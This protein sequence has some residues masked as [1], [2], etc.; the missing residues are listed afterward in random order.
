MILTLE[1]S[2]WKDDDVAGVRVRIN[3]A[4]ATVAD[5]RADI[6][7]AELRVSSCKSSVGV[8]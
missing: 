3:D 2:V 8:G 7:C 5:G 1:L 4:P 6:V